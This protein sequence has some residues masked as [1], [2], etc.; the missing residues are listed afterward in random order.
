MDSLMPLAITDLQLAPLPREKPRLRRRR[1]QRLRA[2]LISTIIVN[3]RQWENTVALTHQLDSSDCMRSGQAEVVLIDNDSESQPLRRCVRYW[4]GVS[5]RCFGRNRGFARAVNEGCRQARGRWLLMM[6]PDVRVP[7][8]FLD[9]VLSAAEKTVAADPKAGIVGFQLRHD[10][11]TRQG[12]SGPA[13]TLGNVL[14][15]L[16]RPRSRRRCQPISGRE[17]KPV[18]WVTG[19]CLLVRRECWEQLGGF[20]EDYFLYYEDV[21]LCRRARDAG[22]SVWYDPAVRVTHFRPL[23]TRRVSA[24]LRLMTRHALLTYAAK[25][26]P[27]WQLRLLGGLVWAEALARQALA[28]TRGQ[29]DAAGH[30]SRL[31]SLVGDLIRGRGLRARHQL[32]CSARTLER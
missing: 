6:N 13:P 16:L 17:R 27:R 24:A 8:E 9:A 18:E 30:F 3:F 26:W 21:D 14:A 25:H 28:K 20:D 19:C 1:R 22:W 7:E 2:P 10:D 4:P 5:L 23:H 31:R 29:H 32:L 11:E 12:S 15:G